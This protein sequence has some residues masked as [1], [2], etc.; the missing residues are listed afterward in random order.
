MQSI[1]KIVTKAAMEGYGWRK[2]LNP[3]MARGATAWPREGSEQ[4][5]LGVR[6]DFDGEVV[7]EGSVF[8]RYKL[9]VNAGRDIPSTLKQWREKAEGGTHAVMADVWVPKGGEKEDVEAALSIA[10]KGV[11]GV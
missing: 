10:H 8:Y 11:V 3:T 1:L 6:Y 4:K 7:V 5:R 9:Q 2:L